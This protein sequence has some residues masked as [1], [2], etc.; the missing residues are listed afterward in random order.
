MT[1]WSK[2]LLLAFLLC[3]AQLSFHPISLDSGNL[4]LHIPLMRQWE[5]TADFV[6][7]PI[8]DAFDH[9]YTLVYPALAS[10]QIPDGLLCEFFAI[11]FIIFETAIFYILLLLWETLLGDGK[12]AML[13][14]I[15]LAGGYFPVLGAGKWHFSFSHQ[16]PGM[17]AALWG[18]YFTI[19]GRHFAAAI[20]F[21]I[22]MNCH[23]MFVGDAVFFW[24]IYLISK[25]EFETL[26]R[27]GFVIFILSLP[28]LAWMITNPAPVL[29]LE[30]WLKVLRVRYANE[31]FPSAFG[32]EWIPFIVF[33]ILFVWMASRRWKKVRE[34]ALPILVSTGILCTA[35]TIFTEIIIV[36]EI[37]KLQLFRSVV[38][39]VLLGLPFILNEILTACKNDRGKY[40]FLFPLFGV[41]TGFFHIPLLGTMTKPLKKFS[42]IIGILLWM[43]LLSGAV[44]SILTK[45][46]GFIEKQFIHFSIFIKSLAWGLCATILFFILGDRNLDKHG[47]W[48]FLVTLIA[49]GIVRSVIGRP[50]ETQP[51]E[52]VDIQIWA[53]NNTS[54]GT[55]FLTPPEIDGF[56]VYSRRGIV[57][58]YKSGGGNGSF[59]TI[60]W[61]ERANSFGA[62]SLSSEAL[63]DA[64]R[65]MS[66]ENKVKLAQRFGASYIVAFR[67]EE[68]QGK[69]VY[70]N[71]VWSVFPARLP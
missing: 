15:T 31:I 40:L 1:D 62:E 3:V 55:I 43:V 28:I 39:L 10:L 44:V 52:W 7:D 54:Q 24:A 51:L 65:K 36:P 47:Y 64:Y 42:Y 32:L 8:A 35:G 57:F 12:I 16:L 29:D 59:F 60:D 53:R 21:G 19:K 22:G 63:G 26:F 34:W 23:A 67:S 18:I 13:S 4:S 37:I 66:I 33:I 48:Y 70:S 71:N 11:L 41:Y 14:A 20:S 49:L 2:R 50:V 25:H 5:G 61:W 58:D 17:L 6:G 27:Y 69:A 46:T 45:E 68:T 30:I 9:F 38:F 56:R